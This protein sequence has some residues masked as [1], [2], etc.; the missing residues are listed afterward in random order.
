MPDSGNGHA[1]T[2]VEGQAG[3][4][5]A[6]ADPLSSS[7]AVD[8]IHGGVWIDDLAGEAAFTSGALVRPNT[9]PRPPTDSDEV[10]GRGV[11]PPLIGSFRGRRSVSTS[12]ISTGAPAPMGVSPVAGAAASAQGAINAAGAKGRGDVKAG[13]QVWS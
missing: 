4:P 2:R 5:A 12:P 11:L 10:N 9:P 7:A 1:S 6:P 3:L 8:G 13:L